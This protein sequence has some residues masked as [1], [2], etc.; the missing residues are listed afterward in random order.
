MNG[1]MKLSW[2]IKVQMPCSCKSDMGKDNKICPLSHFTLFYFLV[3]P[4]TIIQFSL[5]LLDILIVQPLNSF[6]G[7]TLGIR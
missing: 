1:K 4:M 5:I 6:K 3:L 7:V 2:V